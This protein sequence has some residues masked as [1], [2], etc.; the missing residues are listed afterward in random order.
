MSGGV[1]YKDQL[2]RIKA[3]GSSTAACDDTGEEITPQPVRTNPTDRSD[4]SYNHFEGADTGT[5]GVEMN[6]VITDPD[7]ATQMLGKKSKC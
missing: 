4:L 5:K 7:A 6:D 3:G 1:S 2:E